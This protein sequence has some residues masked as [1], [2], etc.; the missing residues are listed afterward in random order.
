MSRSYWNAFQNNIEKIMSI[1]KKNKNK[2]EIPVGEHQS[3]LQKD[4]DT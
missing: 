1:T 2:N 4:A 3:L